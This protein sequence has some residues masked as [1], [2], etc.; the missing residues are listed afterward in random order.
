L[1]SIALNSASLSCDIA[2]P[3]QRGNRWGEQHCG[4][5]RGA[6]PDL[7]GRARRP[8]RQGSPS[9]E[10]RHALGLRARRHGIDL[11]EDERHA[12]AVDT[13]LGRASI[14]VLDMDLVVEGEL[15]AQETA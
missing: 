5:L 10:P 2:N 1:N 13:N 9:Y 7:D 8:R 12:D 14:R 11:D 6:Q 15:E 3:K 4:H